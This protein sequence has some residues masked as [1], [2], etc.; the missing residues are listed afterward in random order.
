MGGPSLVPSAAEL[1]PV[2]RLASFSP[3]ATSLLV[4]GPPSLPASWPS[5]CF[6]PAALSF[7][8]TTTSS[9]SPAPSHAV[10][11]F[12]SWTCLSSCPPPSLG[13]IQP[14]PWDLKCHNWVPNVCSPLGPPKAGPGVPWAQSHLELSVLFLPSLMVCSAHHVNRET[15]SQCFCGKVSATQ[16][17]VVIWWEVVSVRVGLSEALS[18]DT[19]CSPGEVV[20]PADASGCRSG[21]G[22]PLAPGRR[23]CT[24]DRGA[25]C[26]PV[27]SAEPGPALE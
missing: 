13:L 8:V 10:S 11:R 26:S 22:E 14:W 2:L 23:S 7:S 18:G 17:P 5:Y 12:G 19:L 3:S 15:G 24:Q 16:K 25:P 27:P 1:L 4:S 6:S 21:S 20:E 9:S